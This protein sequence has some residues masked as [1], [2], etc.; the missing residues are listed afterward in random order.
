[1]ERDRRAFDEPAPVAFVEVPFAGRI[2][3]LEHVWVDSRDPQAPVAV[4]LHEGL[5]SVALWKDWPAQV[6]AAAGLR[7]LVYSRYGYGRST[8]RP[9]EEQ[10][11]PSFMHTQ[12]EDTLP[13]LLAALGV[14]AHG[15]RYWLIGHSDGGSIALI[16]AARFPERVAGVVAIAPHIMVE[17]VSIAS[18]ERARD[19]WRTTDLPARLARYHAD[20]A[21][22]FGGWNDV[23]LSPAFRDWS[24]EAMLARLRCPVLA[25]Q[26]EDDEYGTLAQVEGIRARVPR[27]ELLVLEHCGHSPHRDQPEALTRAITDFISRHELAIPPPGGTQ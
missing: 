22:A 2:I 23:W 5:G 7:G 21:S 8:P 18:I 12:A 27:A 19:A 25:I 6:C 15:Q 16:H 10:W 26:G 1:M 11:A 24:I 14:G 17:D 4:F 20:P 9:H 13:A 3:R